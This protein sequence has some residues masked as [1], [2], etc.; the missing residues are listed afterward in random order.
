LNSVFDELLSMIE[1]NHG[2][3]YTYEEV[4]DEM[5]AENKCCDFCYESYKVKAR[6]LADAKKEFGNAKRQISN[7]GKSLLKSCN[8]T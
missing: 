4:L 6:S 8:S 7:I 3:Y 1:E 2:E 5:Q